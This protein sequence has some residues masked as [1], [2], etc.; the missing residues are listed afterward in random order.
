MADT[1]VSALPAVT[2]LAGSDAIMAVASGS[3]RKITKTN[4]ATALN[5]G[6][7]AITNGDA[8]VFGSTTASGTGVVT[9][10]IVAGGVPI[11]KGGTGATSAPSARTNLGLTDN[12]IKVHNFAASVVPTASDDSGDGYSVGS[13]WVVTSGG[14]LGKIF[15]ATDV[16]VGAAVWREA[17][18]ENMVTAKGQLLAASG[19]ATVETLTVGSDNTL[20][21]ADASQ[22]TGLKYQKVRP[23]NIENE[24]CTVTALTNANVTLTPFTSDTYQK[25]TGTLTGPV[26]II[27]DTTGAV[28]GQRFS[29]NVGAVT[30]DVTNSLEIR[31]ATSG[32]TLLYQHNPGIAASSATCVDCIFNGTAWI[33]WSQSTAPTT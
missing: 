12:A 26:I 14:S 6:V 8:T 11:A 10:S 2:I 22:A 7:S 32:G 17:M 20:L 23:Q 13:V 27:L 30:A 4:L 15:I 5:A 16:S 24:L 21:V 18:L 28:E 3:S 1:K 33:Q 9:L 31:N 25:F 19:N 29:V